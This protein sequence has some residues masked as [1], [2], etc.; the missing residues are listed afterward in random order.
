MTNLIFCNFILSFCRSIGSEEPIELFVRVLMVHL[1]SR[2]AL[3]RT[4]TS[5]V[6]SAWPGEVWSPEKNGTE[7]F[8]PSNGPVICSTNSSSKTEVLKLN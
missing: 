3:Q 7:S 6:I 4:T 2:S 5:F 1:N 8:P